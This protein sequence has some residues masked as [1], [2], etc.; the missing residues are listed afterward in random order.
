M[1]QLFEIQQRLLNFTSLDFVRSIARKIDWNSRL[2]GIKGARG[3]GKTTLLLQYIKRT[4]A[5]EPEAALYAS[6]DNL[7]FAEHSL[8]ELA[9]D[10]VRM[11]GKHLFLDEVHRYP[12]WSQEIKNIYDNFPQLRVVFTGSSLLEIINAQADLSRRAVMYHL[13]G[14]SFREFLALETGIEFE[15]LSLDDIFHRHMEWAGRITRKIQPFRHFDQYLR[16]GYY[17]YYR[18]QPAL[19]SI[20]LNQ[21][22]NMILEMELP[23]LRSLEVAYIP[24]IKQLLTVL[25]ESVPFTPD[26]SKLSRKIDINRITLIKYLH[27]LKQSDL[28]IL[29]QRNT[30]GI[31]RLQKPDKIYLE[32]TNLM[33]ALAPQRADK[34]HL[35]ETFIVNQLQDFG[36]RL[37][38]WGDFVV[39][40]K[41]ILEVGGKNKSNKQISGLENA[42]IAAD[43]LE[44][45]FGRKIPLWLFGFLY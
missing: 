10:F 33:W 29:M 8:Y 31:G 44:T 39:N 42:F 38:T 6:L 7:W 41:Y 45:G 11:G 24:K 27:Y 34:G 23:Q 4:Y 28:L 12:G 36:I 43:D 15:T 32:N 35:R 1:E 16:Y 13:H 22:I 26:I 14:L 5:G 40:E 30:S 25:A 2:V 21:T 37:A 3:T 19:Y 20:R 18:E 17:P 9:V